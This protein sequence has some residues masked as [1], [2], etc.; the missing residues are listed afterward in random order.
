[1]QPGQQEQSIRNEDPSTGQGYKCDHQSIIASL[2]FESFVLLPGTMNAWPGMQILDKDDSEPSS[3][4]PDDLDFLDSDPEPEFQTISPSDWGIPIDPQFAMDRV[5]LSSSTPPF[6]HPAMLPQFLHPDFPFATMPFYIPP[7]GNFDGWGMLRIKKKKRPGKYKKKN[8][9]DGN[10]KSRNKKKKKKLKKK[11]LRTADDTNDTNGWDGNSKQKK[12]KS[13]NRRAST[14][15]HRRARNEENWSHG[16]FG[17]PIDYFPDGRSRAS[18]S[19]SWSSGT[20][21]FSSTPPTGSRP[22]W[23]NLATPLPLYSQVF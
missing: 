14:W 8:K 3:S 23:L 17:P 4:P 11:E 9:N 1:M 16:V 7:D 13:K 21:T 22:E 2:D 10:S 15:V 20:P 19:D 5:R 18:S 6:Y 12:N